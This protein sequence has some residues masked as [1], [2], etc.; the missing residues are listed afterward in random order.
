MT[1]GGG[2]F[3]SPLRMNLALYGAK[4]ESQ[5]SP[6]WVIGMMLML[7]PTCQ[8]GSHILYCYIL[9]W[10]ICPLAFPHVCLGE[11]VTNADG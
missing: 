11:M 5:S 4:T 9:C 6:Q 1:S 7:I 8:S 10:A 3:F 2:G